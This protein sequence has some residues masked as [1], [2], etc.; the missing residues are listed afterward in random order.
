MQEIQ[1]KLTGPDTKV[2]GH[3]TKIDGER[4]LYRY[5]EANGE[6][7]SFYFRGNIE[8][9]ERRKK[10]ESRD[11]RALRREIL[12]VQ[13][14][15]I[16]NKSRKIERFSLR[17]F[18]EEY[19]ELKAA[20]VAPKTLENIAWVVKELRISFHEI[21]LPIHKIETTM[22]RKWLD[23][24]ILAKTTISKITGEK[25]SR[26]GNRSQNIFRLNLIQIFEAAIKLGLS[27]INP[28]ITLKHLKEKDCSKPLP[29]VED[30]D[31]ILDWM[32]KR[33]L[34]A[35]CKHTSD[36]FKFMFISGLGNAESNALIWRDVD[37]EKGVLSVR[38]K[39]THKLFSIP[40]HPEL[41]AM[42][43]SLREQERTK[44]SSE[45][46]INERHIMKVFSIKRALASAC[47]DLGLPM[48]CPRSFRKLHITTLI[49]QGV[50]IPLVA[51]WQ[52]HQD[53]G[54]LLLRKYSYVVPKH[55]VTAASHVR[56][57]S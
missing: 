31:K 2:T 8:G 26:F 37:F 47:R 55:E 5:I 30:F 40:L 18:I 51:K 6:L 43:E 24:L 20:V 28:A 7:G 4:N 15:L 38:R 19:I 14:E 34:V 45:A 54:A 22:L 48:F 16:Q 21:N 52:G 50:H 3:F 41:R 33:K 32:E 53:G 23:D 29:I 56:L 42:L 44:G 46:Q 9:R 35:D 11:K 1:S 10:L 12:S 17:S 57:H 49:S 39:K 13:D 25:K 27:T 36:Y